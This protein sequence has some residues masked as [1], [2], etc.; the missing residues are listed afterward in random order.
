MTKCTENFRIQDRNTAKNLGA[1]LAPTFRRLQTEVQCSPVLCTYGRPCVP[2]LIFFTQYGN[3]FSQIFPKY[4]KKHHFLH[5]RFSV[6]RNFNPGI[7]AKS[8]DPGISRDRI[9]IKFSSRDLLELFRDFLGLA[10]I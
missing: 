3:D 10:S 9:N 5:T 2:K 7:L 8:R 1:L 4:V 6:L